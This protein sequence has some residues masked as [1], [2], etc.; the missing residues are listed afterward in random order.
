MTAVL[1]EINGIEYIK[2]P[3]AI[4]PPQNDVEATHWAVCPDDSIILYK[5]TDRVLLWAPASEVWLLP[6]DSDNP[7]T[8]YCFDDYL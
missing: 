4:M 3:E 5:I 7:Y 6:S 1:V 2:K 8:L